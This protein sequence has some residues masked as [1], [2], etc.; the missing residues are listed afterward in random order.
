MTTASIKPRVTARA[1]DTRRKIYEAAM[2][3]FREKGFEETTMRDIAAKA[4]VALGGT[5]YYFSSKD[6]IVLAFYHEMQDTSTS[7][8]SDALAEKKKLKDRIRAVL[9]ERLK[10]LEP[11][12]KFC[13]ALFRHA[14][15][16]SDPLSPFSDETRLI[17]DAAIQQMKIAM[18]EGD[19]K[20]PPD[21]KPRLPYL[22]WLYQMALIMFWLYDHSPNQEKT[23]TLMDKSLGLLVNLLRVSSLP[24]MRPLRKTVLELVEA[25]GA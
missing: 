13:A 24:L 11:N 3:M 1:E 7:M 25:A 9:Q 22:L 17:R 19:V 23:Q 5:Y 15:D 2:E 6:A 10:L 18:D 12:R 4:G 8:V 16:G 20:I 21:L 14:P